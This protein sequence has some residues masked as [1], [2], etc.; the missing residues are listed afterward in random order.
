V[1]GGADRA[2]PPAPAP[3]QARAGPPSAHRPKN[4]RS[5]RVQVR[6]ANTIFSHPKAGVADLDLG[7]DRLQVQPA[8]HKTEGRLEARSGQKILKGLSHE[9]DF[10]NVDKNL[11]NLV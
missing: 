7:L 1:A 9:I 2:L 3:R 8:G 11:Q 5:S 10:K 6:P 4:R